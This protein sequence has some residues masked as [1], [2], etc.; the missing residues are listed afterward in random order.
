MKIQIP[1]NKFFGKFYFDE[2]NRDLFIKI[3]NGSQLY[4]IRK[5]SELNRKHEGHFFDEIQFFQIGKI[6]ESFKEHLREQNNYFEDQYM[7]Q[8]TQNSFEN[9]MGKTHYVK[10][11]KSFKFR[12][13]ALK[14]ATIESAKNNFVILNFEAQGK[15]NSIKM[16]KWSYDDHFEN[17]YFDLWNEET[18]YEDIKNITT[19]DIFSNYVANDFIA[20]HVNSNEEILKKEKVKIAKHFDIKIEYNLFDKK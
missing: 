5:R 4:V 14:T 13:F 17:N 18:I 11:L 19:D 20:H 1:F 8:M 6:M 16:R 12:N 9:H 3:K 7:P 2:K 10:L 15:N